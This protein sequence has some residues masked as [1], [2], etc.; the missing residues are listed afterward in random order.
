MAFSGGK[1]FH[2]ELLNPHGFTPLPHTP[3]VVRAVALAV[4]GQAGV[5]IDASIY[6]HQALFRLPNTRHAKSG[7]YKRLLDPDDLDRL[8]VPAVL[9]M[10]RHPAGFR[11]PIHRDGCEQL[12]DDLEAAESVILAGGHR[13][14]GLRTPP[15]GSPAVPKFVRDFIGF[16]DV[17]EPG[18]AVTLFRCAAALSEAYRLHGPEAVVR[19]LLEEVALKSGLEPAEVSKALRDG[20][21]KGTGKGVSV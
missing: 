11:L 7:R 14:C 6:H 8:T 9:D 17:Q 15:P 16:G 19:G 21:A 3:D 4:A 2:A 5:R 12:A 1:G 18:R 10:A 20:I 13:V